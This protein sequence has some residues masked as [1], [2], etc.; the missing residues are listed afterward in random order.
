MGARRDPGRAGPRSEAGPYG[1][2]GR[3]RGPKPRS[4]G[5]AGLVSVRHEIATGSSWTTAPSCSNCI[6]GTGPRSPV[7]RVCLGLTCGTKPRSLVADVCLGL[8][9]PGRLGAKPWQWHQR[10]PDAKKRAPTGALLVD[11]GVVQPPGLPWWRAALAASRAALRSALAASR[12]ALAAARSASRSALAAS[13]AAFAAARAAGSL[14]TAL[15]A[16]P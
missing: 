14:A 6:L 12:A 4:E 2:P 1:G 7:P 3:I 13:R 5:G 15:T 9:N 8:T 11:P 10:R 16:P